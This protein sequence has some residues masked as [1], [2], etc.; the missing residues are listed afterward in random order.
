MKLLRM[1]LIAGAVALAVAGCSPQEQRAT[2]G[3]LV[4]GG[5]GAAVGAIATNGDA[6]GALVGGAI[7][8]ASGAMIGAATAPRECYAQDAWGRSVV[9]PCNQGAVVNAPPPRQSPQACYVRDRNGQLVQVR[10]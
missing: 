4:G 7:G 8:A 6:G 2:T 3:A 10:C 9:V 5:L 1:S